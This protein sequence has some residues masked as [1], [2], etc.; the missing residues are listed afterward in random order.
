MQISLPSRANAAGG[1]TGRGGVLFVAFLAILAVA[2]GGALVVFGPQMRAAQEAERAQAID[3]E[4][5]AFC[6]KLG[7]GP[8]TAR[9]GECTSALN[10]IRTLHE[11]RTLREAGGIL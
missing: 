2:L 7:L 11:T 8:E 9:Y 5:Y 1:A 6:V 3:A 4:N 10:D